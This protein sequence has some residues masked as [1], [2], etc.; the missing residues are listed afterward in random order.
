MDKTAKPLKIFICYG[1]EIGSQDESGN[2]RYPEPNNESVALK[3]KAY[4]ESLGHEVWIPRER[5]LPGDDW[6]RQIFNG[7]ELADVVLVCLTHKTLRPNS[8]CRE[9]LSYATGVCKKSVFSIQ[10]ENMEDGECPPNLLK[11]QILTNFQDWRLHWT[12]ESIDDAWFDQTLESLDKSLQK[13]MLYSGEMRELKKLL[14]PWIINDHLRRLDRGTQVLYN[15]QTHEFETKIVRKFCGRKSIFNLFEDKIIQGDNG[16]LAESDR[17]LWLKKGP[18]FGKSRF[19]AELYYRY[20]LAIGAVYFIEYNLLETHKP[21]TFIKSISYQL[22]H[23]NSSYRKKLLNYLNENQDTIDLQTGDPQ[24]LFKSLIVDLLANESDGEKLTQWILVDALD[25]ATENHR[26]EIASLISENLDNLPSWLCFFITSRDCDDAVNR[27]LAQFAPIEFSD[28]ENYCDLREY[29]LHEC[30][31]MGLS[32][33]DD[34]LINILLEKS[35]GSFLYPEMVFRDL[36]KDS[37]TIDNIINLPSGVIGYI[38]SQFARLF[39]E[40]SK[41]FKN[42][43]RPMLSYILTS[44]EPIPR[45]VLKYCLG[46]RRESE[47]DNRLDLLGTLFV[48]SGY[49]DEDT[50]TPFQNGIIDYCFDKNKSG[51]YYVYPDEAKENFA[52]R[53]MELYKSG[54]LQWTTRTDEEPNTVQRY[55]LN[56][57]PSHLM[58]AN[59]T[60]EASDVLS[61]FAFLMKRL[62][63]GSVE[64]VI[65]DYITFRDKLSGASSVCDAYFDVICSNAHFLRRNCEDNRAYKIMLQIA[66][67]IADAC[68]VT[69]AAQRWLNPKKETSPCDWIWLNKASRSKEYS[70]NPCKLV[71]ENSDNH[72][73]FA[74]NEGTRVNNLYNEDKETGTSNDQDEN[75]DAAL[76][77]VLSS[78]DILTWGESDNVLR[79]W[80]SDGRCK[81][82]LKG[83]TSSIIN[84]IELRS[85][86]I[87][88][89]G[90]FDYALRLWSPDG[91]CKS[92]LEGHTGCITGALELSSGDILS[93]GFDN[94]LRLWFP[95]GRCK[96]VLEGHTDRI[97]GVIEHCS[98]D[99]L[100][101]SKDN[102]MRY[103]SPNA[104]GI[105]IRDGHTQNV[106]DVIELSTG[107]ILSRDI[108]RTIRIWSQDG[109]CKEVIQTDNPQ[110]RTF[111]SHFS[112][113]ATNRSHNPFS[114]KLSNWGIEL[115][116]NLNPVARWNCPSC[117]YRFIGDRRICVWY[118]RDIEFL[119]INYGN[120]MG[121]TFE[122]AQQQLLADNRNN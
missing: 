49:T 99:I 28:Y 91:V 14:R 33:S 51:N 11:D 92:V 117:H 64:R 4:L 16:V 61:D 6:R 81:A 90:A 31:E 3:I 23:T 27:N 53:G 50:I 44:C 88:S 60:K 54:E 116:Y 57:L 40:D 75:T 83:H 89:W 102:T 22:A 8:V 77:M 84:A 70:P 13:V 71:I 104:T 63:F 15:E 9:I 34:K 42:E 69:Q 94:N 12:A 68:P 18:A 101:W 48:Q 86:D 98:G 107:E 112:N 65:M 26:N 37:L 95:D 73:L 110:Y 118:G 109:I 87:L 79:I 2:L 78:G 24:T 106:E 20:S 115:L 46:I 76:S 93:W 5:I 67:D 55:F 43:V 100:S 74:V 120:R 21:L 10:L 47:L 36:N 45:A 108:G 29:I 122:Q 38:H 59:M 52:N 7:I 121:I 35:D 97:K 85:G 62:R 58:N 56:W 96:A 119:Q 1:H 32:I 72:E 17:V 111:E 39:F 103:W 19:A 66:S 114:V 105:S 82:V 30:K 25:K 80:S 113:Q 41:L